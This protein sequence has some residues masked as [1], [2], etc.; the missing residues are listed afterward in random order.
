M[1]RSVQDNFIGV[2]KKE[3]VPALGCTEPIAVAYAAA[4]ARETLGE[5]PGHVV[6]KCS[7]NIIKN[8]K[9]VAVPNA[10]GMRGVATAAV[11]GIVGGAASR[12]LEV[13]EEVTHDHVIRTKELLDRPDFCV[14]SLVRGV[15]NL[16]IEVIVSKDGHTASVK[17]ENKHTNITEITKDGKTL[18]SADA[19]AGSAS[20]DWSPWSLSSIIEFARTV[21]TAEVRD[22]L[23]TQIN[24]NTAI[25]EEGLKNEYGAEVGRTL[26]EE[27]GDDIK[28]RAAA[29]AAAGSDARMGGCSL[30][31]VI[32]SGSGNQGMTVSL[33][34]IEY[35]KELGT[36]H[37]QLLR[38]LL[39]SNL[40]SI[41]Q[42]HY[43]GSLSA[44]CGAVTASA[45]AAAAI[46]Y[47]HGDSD[48]VIAQTVV[49]TL[50]NVGGIVC[51]GAKSSCAAKIASSVNAGIM[52][53]KMARKGRCFQPGEGIVESGA[54]R[55][56][57]NV[58]Y[59]GRVGMAETDIE[60]LGIMI[61][62]VDVDKQ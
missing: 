56:I 9:G 6:V 27:F 50:A 47:L 52:A 1:E 35:A 14:Q 48:D 34:V 39:I 15:A 57:R 55:T 7:G 20:V 51:D 23:E 62:A 12:E 26:R 44:F 59:M 40:I 43:I 38:A 4:K 18:H 28:I 33:P 5:F 41:Y 3:L 42:K 29:A 31:V 17:I 10:E 46:A 61:G 58:G 49:N 45:G 54:E 24:Y 21:D 11:L 36:P 19:G 22:I 16:Y 30:A 32:N 25:S 60:I 2:L 37:E 53:W 13:L 8:V